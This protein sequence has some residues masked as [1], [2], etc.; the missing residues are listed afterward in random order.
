[1]G[2]RVY[3]AVNVAVVVVPILFVETNV[4]T[5]ASNAKLHVH[6]NASTN[7]APVCV[8]RNVIE[9][10][11]MYNVHSPYLVVTAVQDTVGNHA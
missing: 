6:G 4:E 9:S 8:A 1:V 5:N 10:H 11:V 7:N 2:I 3:H